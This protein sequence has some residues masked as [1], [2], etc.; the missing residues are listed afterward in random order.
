MKIT[1]SQLRKIIA[2]EVSLVSEAG[3]AVKPMKKEP[4]KDVKTEVRYWLVFDED[5]FLEGERMAKAG[6]KERWWGEPKGPV[7]MTRPSFL[8]GATEGQVAVPKKFYH[9]EEETVTITKIVTKTSTV[10]RV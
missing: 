6:R 10:R 2:E 8:Q 4:Q 9:F 7:Y 5:Y 1:A 3:T